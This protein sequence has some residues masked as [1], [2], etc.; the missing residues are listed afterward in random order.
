MIRSTGFRIGS[1]ARSAEAGLA[2]GSI[3]VPNPLSPF[4]STC[5][6]SGP[7][8]QLVDLPAAAPSRSVGPRKFA[9]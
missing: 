7:I 1:R 5:V 3:A 2:P 9:A 4:A 6:C 8:A